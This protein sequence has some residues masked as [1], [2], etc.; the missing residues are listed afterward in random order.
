[1]AKVYI[2]KIVPYFRG[3]YISGVIYNRLDVVGYLG[4]SYVCNR[5][6]VSNIPPTNS[7]YWVLV[8]KK[9]DTGNVDGVVGNKIYNDF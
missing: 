8:A 9:G 7:T 3:E 5:D 1:M 4:S 6:G 2:G